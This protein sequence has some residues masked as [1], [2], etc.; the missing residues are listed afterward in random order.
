M[1]FRSSTSYETRPQAAQDRLYNNHPRQDSYDKNLQS[2][3]SSSSTDGYND[4]RPNYDYPS[5]HR[6]PPPSNNRL[7]SEDPRYGDGKPPALPSNNNNDITKRDIYSKDHSP[8]PQSQPRSRDVTPP[9]KPARAPNSKPRSEED[10]PITVSA[11][12]MCAYC[13]QELGMSFQ[14]TRVC[15]CNIIM[16]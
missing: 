12:Y 5:G 2:G 15:Q 6:A 3:Y 13:T 9:S 4:P 7:P 8:D 16:V 1:L 11:K 14:T 10:E